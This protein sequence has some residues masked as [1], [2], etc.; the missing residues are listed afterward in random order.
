LNIWDFAG[1]LNQY[2]IR[3]EFYSELHAIIYVFDLTNLISF[4]NLDNWIKEC[5]R[6]GGDKLIPILIGN[7]SDMKKEISSNM[8]ENFVEKYKFN[9]Y[10]L[11][12]KDQMG[13]IKFFNDFA[14]IVN[15]MKPKDRR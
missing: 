3:C 12:F 1:K 9:Y 5:K 2:K 8:I 10:E 14:S 15:E 4:N 7:K 11:S 6:N 13:V